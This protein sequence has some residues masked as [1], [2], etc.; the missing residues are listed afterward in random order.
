MQTLIQLRAQ[1][2]KEKNFALGDQIRNDLQANG[3]ILKDTPEGT[4]WQKT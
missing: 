3:I 2:R 4:T 1:A